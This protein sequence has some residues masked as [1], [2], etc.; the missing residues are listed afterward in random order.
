MH[1]FHV[2]FIKAYILHIT[3]S[4]ALLL[5]S[6]GI[7]VGYC[8]FR[9]LQPTIN[10]FKHICDDNGSISSYKDKQDRRVWN[11]AVNLQNE[12]RSFNMTGLK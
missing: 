5:A 3:Y 12:Y 11:L 10:K 9:D 8:S 2:N 6:D 1:H 7:G 4:E